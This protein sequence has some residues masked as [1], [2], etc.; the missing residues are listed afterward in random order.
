MPTSCSAQVETRHDAEVAAAAPQPPEQVGVLVGRRPDQLTV[1][2]HH[3][4]PEGV[5]AG[6]PKLPTQPTDT[7]AERQPAD[8]RVR[9]DP[10]RRRQPER[11]RR[12]VERA[13]QR[14]A[15]HLRR[16]GTRVDDDPRIRRQVDHQPIVRHRPPRR[17]VPAASHTE[18]QTELPRDPDRG[19]HVLRA[20]AP[21]DVAGPTVDGTVPERRGPAS[22][23]GA[24]RRGPHPRTWPAAVRPGAW[25]DSGGWWA[26][27]PRRA[28]LLDGVSGRL[29][30]FV[31]PRARRSPGRPRDPCLP[32][33][34]RL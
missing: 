33:P 14:P 17:T 29:P 3:L 18:R 15:L 4:V 2:G 21:H 27:L 19:T 8:T 12:R 7:A 11:L 25:H 32:G 30:P 10:R 6:Q 13:E 1:G 24:R 16:P 22:Y 9:H 28:I 5:V 34:E 23:P 26:R 31:R 20:G